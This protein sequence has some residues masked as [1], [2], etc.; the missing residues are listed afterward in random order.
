MTD[1][2]IMSDVLPWVFNVR[3]RDPA[4]GVTCGE[5]I[6]S[7]AENFTRL[8]S[9]RDYE[10]LPPRRRN[11]VSEA[12]THNRSTAFGVPGGT[13]GP[14]M[15]RLDFLCK[16]TMFGGIVQD[17]VLLRR[18]CGDVLPCTFVLKCLKR[19]ALTQ[20]EIRD[21]EVRIRAAE[22]VPR[23]RRATVEPDSEEEEEG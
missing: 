23:G 6:D 19:Y 15:R 21:Q 12:Y 3:A 22:Q 9:S 10:S 14:G 2:R 4:V 1:I 17:E 20:D 16:D 5:L 13:L 8:S 11:Q 18:L 7:L